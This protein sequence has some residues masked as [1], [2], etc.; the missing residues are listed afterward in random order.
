MSLRTCQILALAVALTLTGAARAQLR[1]PSLG[2]TL[3]PIARAPA[4]QRVEPLVDTVLA[5]VDLATARLDEATR[6]ARAHRRE[7]DRDLHEVV[8]ILPMPGDGT[9][10]T[11]QPRQQGRDLCAQREGRKAHDMMGER[12]GDGFSSRVATLYRT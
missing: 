11:A 3:Q 6:R 10:E 12:R 9:G 1:L 7:L 5:P 8:R 4:L 2:S